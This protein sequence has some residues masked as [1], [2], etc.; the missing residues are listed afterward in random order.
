MGSKKIKIS[1]TIHEEYLSSL[2]TNEKQLNAI[3]LMLG[4]QYS[5]ID[6]N[7]I[8]TAVD[9]RAIKLKSKYVRYFDQ[10]DFKDIIPYAKKPIYTPMQL[11]GIWR[12]V[13]TFDGDIL[14]ITAIDKQKDDEYEAILANVFKTIV[15]NNCST[16][17]YI[18]VTFLLPTHNPINENNLEGSTSNW[19][20]ELLEE[21]ESKRLIRDELMWPLK[22]FFTFNFLNMT[23][24]IQQNNNGSKIHLNLLHS[25]DL[26]GYF[27]FYDVKKAKEWTKYLADI[28]VEDI[29]FSEFNIY[30]N[31]EQKNKKSPNITKVDNI[32]EY[33]QQTYMAIPEFIQQSLKS[34]IKENSYVPVNDLLFP[35]LK[36]DVKGVDFG[37]RH[38]K[39]DRKSK[40]TD[41]QL[42]DIQEFKNALTYLF[43][44]TSG[45]AITI[46]LPK[47][48]VE[49]S[50]GEQL[51]SPLVIAPEE[52]L[53]VIQGVRDDSEVD[54]QTI[55]DKYIGEDSEL[56]L[57]T[58]KNMKKNERTAVFNKIYNA[59]IGIE[60]D[61]NIGEKLFRRFPYIE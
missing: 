25:L 6:I 12:K 3:K 17:S 20:F 45:T 36:L 58:V 31:P 10:E 47:E 11:S 22:L 14:A 48:E 1:K 23:Q 27:D 19:T 57:K 41:Y 49:Y 38:V 37:Y 15:P 2:S 44:M 21:Q 24:C 56:T 59:C 5:N 8:S 61:V 16:K 51:T 28:D 18:P 40:H 9:K 7:N 43:G 54:F 29:D 53:S 50:L 35:S 34:G 52:W 33:E 39:N 32:F 26:L 55:Y 60:T 30:L 13:G 42:N 46:Q 4:W